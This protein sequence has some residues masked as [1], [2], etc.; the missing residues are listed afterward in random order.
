MTSAGRPELMWE[1]FKLVK[2][3]YLIFY[4]Y[5]LCT[6]HYAQSYYDFGKRSLAPCSFYQYDFQMIFIS[7]SIYKQ[8]IMYFNHPLKKSFLLL[9]C[10]NAYNFCIKDLFEML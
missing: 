8:I 5:I 3:P 7:K 1:P 10:I 4:L 6:R 2:S 9:R